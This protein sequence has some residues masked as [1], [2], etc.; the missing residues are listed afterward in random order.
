MG[1][2][3]ESPL[4]IMG[5]AMKRT[6]ARRRASARPEAYG[7][8]REANQLILLAKFSV[9]AGFSHHI[10]IAV[11]PFGKYRIDISR[12]FRVVEFHAKGFIADEK[13]R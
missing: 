13:N 9:G 11:K 6:A 12:R 2:A 8:Q 10:F 1:A 5:R 7:W 4:P 3:R